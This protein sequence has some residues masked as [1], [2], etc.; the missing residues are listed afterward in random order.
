MKNKAYYKKDLSTLRS[1]NNKEAT[2]YNLEIFIVNSLKEKIVIIKKIV[3]SLPENDYFHRVF[4]QEYRAIQ[5]EL[6]K[7]SQIKKRLSKR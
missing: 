6:Y 7:H 3:N 1:Y 4:K 5:K 2:C